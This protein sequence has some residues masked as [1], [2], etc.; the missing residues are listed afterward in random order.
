MQPFE[1]NSIFETEAL[2]SSDN[3]NE[4]GVMGLIKSELYTSCVQYG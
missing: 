2:Q 1:K 3:L 4:I